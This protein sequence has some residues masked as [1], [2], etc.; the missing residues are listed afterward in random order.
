MKITVSL[1]YEVCAAS[2]FT[3]ELDHRL[4]PSDALYV[5]QV[6]VD[7]FF[8]PYISDEESLHT[9]LLQTFDRL[10]TIIPRHA[11]LIDSNLV[12]SDDWEEIDDLLRQDLSE[13]TTLA[14]TC[15]DIT[16]C[17]GEEG[18]LDRFINCVTS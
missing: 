13:S 12:Q 4:T 1:Y 5:Y 18:S 11:I 16:V 14:F 8:R 2:L 6:C 3:V 17:C 10:E 9:L 15:N 7:E